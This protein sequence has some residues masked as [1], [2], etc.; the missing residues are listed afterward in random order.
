MSAGQRRLLTS[1]NK[2]RSSVSLPYLISSSSF[3]PLQ[4]LTW[5][6]GEEEAKPSAF[7]YNFLNADMFCVFKNQ[8]AIYSVQRASWKPNHSCYTDANGEL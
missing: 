2:V 1:G 3:S 7:M 4:S 5:G 8:G 6:D